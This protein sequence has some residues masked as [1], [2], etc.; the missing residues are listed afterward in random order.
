MEMRNTFL[1]AKVNFVL[2]IIFIGS[3]GLTVTSFILRA[4]ELD[5]PIT[6]S[7]EQ[8][9]LEAGSDT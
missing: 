9:F 1:V 7:M 2:A 8:R 5:D 3:F 4:A 6:G